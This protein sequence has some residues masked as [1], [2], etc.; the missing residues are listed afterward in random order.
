MNINSGAS[1]SRTFNYIQSDVVSWRDKADMLASTAYKL[2]ADRDPQNNDFII[3][4]YRNVYNMLI[5]FALENYYKGAIIAKRLKNGKH[6]KSDELDSSIKK[7]QLVELASDAGVVLKDR[8]HESYLKYITEC[9]FWRGRYPS[10]TDASGIGGS[11]TYHP[12]K[13]GEEFCFLTSLE[14]GI[15]IDTA[16]RLIDQAKSN[17]DRMLPKKDKI[18]EKLC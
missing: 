2:E 11:I 16:H 4:R 12:P 9:V 14:H 13:E 15:T 17:V 3:F 10:P 18:R 5:G 8:L 7:H 6:I 1:D